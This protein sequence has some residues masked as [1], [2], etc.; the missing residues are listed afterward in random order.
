[1]WEDEGSRSY[2]L[3]LNLGPEHNWKVWWDPEATGSHHRALQPLRAADSIRGPPV[4]LGRWE[5]GGGGRPWPQSLGWG[6]WK[7]AHWYWEAAHRGPSVDA[8]GFQF[9]LW[10]SRKPRD[11]GGGGVP[12]VRE[13]R[14][15]SAFPSGRGILRSRCERAWPQAGQGDS[16]P[17]ARS[18]RERP[19]PAAGPFF[20]HFPRAVPGHRVWRIGQTDRICLQSAGRRRLGKLVI[21]RLP[22]DTAGPSV[23]EGRVG[24]GV[25]PL[26]STR[27][28]PSICITPDGLLST[29]GCLARDRPTPARSVW[30]FA[31]TYVGRA[32]SRVTAI[33]RHPNWK[34]LPVRAAVTHIS[35]PKGQKSVPVIGRVSFVDTSMRGDPGRLV[36][37]FPGARGRARLC[38]P[39][40]RPTGERTRLP[41]SPA[42]ARVAGYLP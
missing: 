26:G 23:V 33:A 15:G 36:P 39:R 32:R 2:T 21:P 34:V 6:R 24:K 22:V 20:T 31:R 42:P 19:K 25:F 7:T 10:D 14:K 13:P 37:S 40:P 35:D 11:P 8:H 18:R 41:P 4:A 9:R 17:L 27:W 5:D 29:A 16:G 1:M 3:R 12:A 30:Y 28:P 38:P